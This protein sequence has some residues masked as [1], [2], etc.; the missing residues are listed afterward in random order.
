MSRLKAKA[1]GLI[2]VVKSGEPVLNLDRSV[3]AET[4]W[5]A[6]LEK[7]IDKAASILRSFFIDGFIVPYRT[8]SMCPQNVVSGCY[9]LAVFHLLG[10]NLRSPIASGSGI[11]TTRLSDGKWSD[12]SGIL[13][14]F[15]STF[16]P[17]LDV[18]DVVLV[19]NDLNSAEALSGPNVNL[20]KSITIAPGPILRSEAVTNQPPPE[21]PHNV[22]VLLY[23]K[24][25]AELVDLDPK[26]LSIRE[27]TNGNEQFYGV[28]GISAREILSGRV[29]A[30]SGVSNSLSSTIQVLEE[31]THN[32][33]DD[34]RAVY[35][36]YKGFNANES[37][38]KRLQRYYED[39]AE[40]HS[41][42]FYTFPRSR[43]SILII[44]HKRVQLR[45]F[46]A[47]LLRFF[48]EKSD[49]DQISNENIE[50][51]VTSREETDRR[52][53]DDWNTSLEEGTDQSTG[54]VDG[55]EEETGTASG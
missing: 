21:I 4:L 47:L 6:C 46:N 23:A 11:I 49:V 53:L 32:Y 10:E 12:A 41:R 16:P 8:I 45:E 15:D 50:I 9:G 38:F 3:Y 30:P 26:G 2:D 43:M 39:R 48:K 37:S 24:G 7:E 18:L 27:Y 55:K 19:L 36:E 51:R 20:G 1:L 29:K 5:P 25:K 52:L 54:R 42:I 22:S 35:L 34:P 33:M 13:V 14:D 40:D 28:A 31:Q 17:G 44:I